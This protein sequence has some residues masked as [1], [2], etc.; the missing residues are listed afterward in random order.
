MTRNLRV[1]FAV[2]LIAAL[3][4]VAAPAGAAKAK[5]TATAPGAPTVTS[6]T[7]GTKRTLR[8]VFTAPASN[9]G[10]PISHYRATCSSSD[11][12]KTRAGSARKLLI[13]VRGLTAG[14][15]YTCTV[16]ARNRAGLGPSSA[17]SSAVVASAH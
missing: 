5:G 3:A 8:V 14:K 16:R 15:T 4:L 12:G 17:P 13:V 10:A 7:A 1:S 2:L 11:G 9:G 6:A